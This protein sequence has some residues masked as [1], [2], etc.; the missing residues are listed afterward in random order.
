MLEVE[1]AELAELAL[2]AD[3]LFTAVDEEDGFA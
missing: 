1:Q 3:R 2:T